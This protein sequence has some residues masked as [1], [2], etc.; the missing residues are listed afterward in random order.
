MRDSN[1]AKSVYKLQKHRVLCHSV[2]NR[3]QKIHLVSPKT[4]VNTVVREKIREN[5][6]IPHPLTVRPKQQVHQ[7]PADEI[8]TT[9]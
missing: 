6:A 3:F 2:Y 4:Y 9:V 8:V 5:P 1:W 7:K